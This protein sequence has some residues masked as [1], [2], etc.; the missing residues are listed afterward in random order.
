MA[1]IVLRSRFILAQATG[2]SARFPAAEITSLDEI[3]SDTNVLSVDKAVENLVGK[4]W[5]RGVSGVEKAQQLPVC[6]GC[7]FKLNS[8]RELQAG[9]PAARS[10]RRDRAVLCPGAQSGDFFR[11]HQ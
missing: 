2:F 8:R 7:C 10:V 11:H 6:S 5:S 4:L 1:A 9:L 3:Q